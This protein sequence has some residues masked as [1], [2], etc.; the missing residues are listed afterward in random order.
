[1]IYPKILEELIE[2]LK[3]LPSIGE[4]SAERLALSI[5]EFT[6]EDNESFSL[7]IKN[8]KKKLQKCIICG[9]ISESEKCDICLNEFRNHSM[10]CVVEDY[11]SIFM[12]EK[13]GK[14]EGV[15]HVLNG[16][17]SPIDGVNPDDINISQLIDRCRA[18]EKKELEIIIAL[19][20]TLEG[21][22]TT[23]YISNLLSSYENI[24]I[25]RLSYGIPMGAEIDYLDSLTLERALK[26]RKNLL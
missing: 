12:F 15:Y 2:Y 17:I 1:M 5:L 13:I 4:K 6:Q 23:M 16:L 8:V 19:K 3:K 9:H 20:P 22:T 24:K 10:I 25:S 26:D 7:S 14:Y 11:K 21:E 18:S